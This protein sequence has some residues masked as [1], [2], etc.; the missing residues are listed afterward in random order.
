MNLKM[1]LSFLIA[2]FAITC[3]LDVKSNHYR[4]TVLTSDWN[5]LGTFIN[6]KSQVYYKRL[7]SSEVYC[8]EK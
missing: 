5:N 2:V 6:L 1:K 8:D 7:G 4:G 3:P